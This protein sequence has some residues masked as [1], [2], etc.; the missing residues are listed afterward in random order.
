MANSKQLRL[1]VPDDPLARSSGPPYAARNQT[2]STHPYPSQA[3]GDEGCHDNLTAREHEIA[4][5]VARGYPNKTI[6]AVLEIS[7]W[8]VATHIRRMYNKLDVHSRAALV[9]E[10]FRRGWQ[11]RR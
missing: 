6:A 1:Q 3:A 4:R 5:L 10:L 8:T 9:T 11:F 7:P 2:T